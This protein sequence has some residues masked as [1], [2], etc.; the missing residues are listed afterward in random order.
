MDIE[1]GAA[2]VATLNL[3]PGE[4]PSSIPP[5]YRVVRH[6]AV[7]RVGLDPD[8]VEAWLKD[9]GGFV[10]V[11]PEPILSGRAT[12]RSK[13]GSIVYAIPLGALSTPQKSHLW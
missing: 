4:R 7:V 9:V 10:S 3:L 2:I 6:D 13:T 1:P 12:W 11:L 8:A 5:E